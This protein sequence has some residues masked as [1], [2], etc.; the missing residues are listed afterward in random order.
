MDWISGIRASKRDKSYGSSYGIDGLFRSLFLLLLP[1]G[2]HLLDMFRCAWG[3]IWF[4]SSW[5][6]ISHYSIDDC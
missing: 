1:A 5:F 4:I 3:C 2:G 6:V